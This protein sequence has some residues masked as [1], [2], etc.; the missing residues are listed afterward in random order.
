M[1]YIIAGCDTISKK[2]EAVMKLRILTLT[3][4]LAGSALAQHPRPDMNGPSPEA[5]ALQEIDQAPDE[6]KK[7]ALCEQFVSQNPK[8]EAV[9]WIYEQMQPAYLKAGQPDK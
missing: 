4:I 7:L 2:Q 9:G 8:H 1:V 5:R 6:A 3:L